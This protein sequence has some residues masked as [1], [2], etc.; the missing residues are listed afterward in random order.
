MKERLVKPSC[1]EYIWNLLTDYDVNLFNIKNHEFIM[2]QH[3][4][5]ADTES[6]KQMMSPEIKL[7]VSVTL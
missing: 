6:T 7:I 5:E 1:K 2:K 4:V 3:E